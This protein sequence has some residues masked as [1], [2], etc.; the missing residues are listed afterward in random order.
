MTNTSSRILRDAEQAVVTPIAWRAST[1]ALPSRTKPNPIVAREMLVGTARRLKRINCSSRIA[2]VSSKK[3]IN[4]AS[5]KEKTWG[6]S[7]PKASCSRFS[8]N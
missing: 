2:S 3:P 5:P 6:S 1:A 4:G 7:R 8:T